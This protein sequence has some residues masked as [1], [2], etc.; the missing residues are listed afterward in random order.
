[1]KTEKTTLFLV[2]DDA[3]FLKLLEIEFLNH[4]EYAVK[5]FPT[6]ELCLESLSE[7]PEVIVLDYHL[8]GSEKNAMN[9]IEVLRRIKEAQADI[10]VVMLSEQDKIDV[11]VDCLH[12]GA[13]DYLVKSETAFIRLK[14]IL[15]D[16]RAVRKMKM[17]LHWYM[18]RM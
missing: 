1:M 8:D 18:S 14:K 12:H 7:K 5:C 2:D 16:L 15:E 17:T 4:G 10:P 13:V 3:V 11:A 6:G 9:G